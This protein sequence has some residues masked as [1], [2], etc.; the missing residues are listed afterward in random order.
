[1]SERKKKP[2]SR[3][4]AP[5]CLNSRLLIFCW[6][7]VWLGR[8]RALELE[9]LPELSASFHAQPIAERINVLWEAEL[10]RK[11]PSLPR[12][13]LRF[14]SFD[15]TMGF[16]T[17]I[18][19]GMLTAAARPFLLRH[20]VQNVG[21]LALSDVLLLSV[22]LVLEAFFQSWNKQFL[23]DRL[24]CR[25]GAACISLISKRIPMGAGA[26]QSSKGGAQPTEA[27]LVGTDVVRTL[28]NSMILIQFFT[29]I[30]Q[31]CCSVVVLL[32]IVGYPSLLGIAICVMCVFGAGRA[33]KY[34]KQIDKRVLQQTDR[35]IGLLKQILDG[36][37]FIKVSG[38]E[39]FYMDKSTSIRSLETVQQRRYRIF[40]SFGITFGR[41]T[42]P[43]ASMATFVFM[44]FLEEPLKASDVFAAMS[45]FM[46][47]RMPLAVIPACMN[48]VMTAL[49]SCNRIGRVISAPVVAVPPDTDNPMNVLALRDVDL[50]W[51]AEAPL[52]LQGVS[53]DIRVG[54]SVGV[55]GSVAS[56]KSTLLMS[57]IGGLVPSKGVAARSATC[58]KISYVPQRPIVFSGSLLSNVIMGD[59]LDE[60]HLAAAL[61]AAQF[62]RD[63]ELMPGGL[64]TEIGERGTTLSGGQQMRL[65]IARALYHSPQLLVAD[66]PIAA[67]DVH[68]GGLIFAAL[69][70]W[71]KGPSRV[72][73]D[74][75]ESRTL[76]MSLNQLHMLPDFHKVVYLHGGRVAFQGTPSELDVAKAD[77]ESLSSLLQSAAMAVTVDDI[78]V[79]AGSPVEKRAST[80]LPFE[81]GKKPAGFLET[82]KEQP[83]TSLMS[84]SS[85]GKL[86]KEEHRVRGSMSNNVLL[87]YVIAVGAKLSTAYGLSCLVTYALL[88][89]NDWYLAWWM[90]ELEKTS[91]DSFKY[92]GAAI[93]VGLTLSHGAGMIISN[94]FCASSGARAARNLHKTSLSSVL[95]AP[96]S[97]FEETP[98]GRI[99]SKFSADL[100][101]V[102]LKLPL[103]IDHFIVVGS[104]LMVFSISIC[105][106]VPWFALFLVVLIPV[107]FKL[108]SLVNKSSREIKRMTNMA[109]SPVLTFVQEASA[110]RLLLRLMKQE[111]WLHNETVHYIDD[112]H[113]LYFN[114][115]SMLCFLRLVGS[116]LGTS[117]SVSVI[118]FFWAI[119]SL[120][121]SPPGGTSNAGLA[122]AYAFIIPY[123][124]SYLTLFAS[125]ARLFL[126][127]L[128]RLLE[129]QS[130]RM[131][132]EKPWSCKG[133]PGENWPHEG[134]IEFKE[135]T[136]RYK[137][138]LPAAVNSL[139]LTINGGERLGVVGRTG[140]G[141]SSL[142]ILLLRIVEPDGGTVLIDGVD[143]CEIGLHAL[144]RAVAVV[145]QEP[146]LFQGPLRQNLDPLD[147]YTE[148]ALLEALSRVSLEMKL[149]TEVGQGGGQLSAGERQLIAIARA[150]MSTARIIIM[151]EPTAN[152]DTQTDDRLQQVTRNAFKSRTVLCIAHRLNT[153]MEYD[154][155][156]VMEAGSV[157]EVD[158]PANL[159]AMPT[160][161]FAQMVSKMNRGS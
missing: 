36:V 95:H 3:P 119:P 104:T 78:A 70:S 35:R 108:D 17:S 129:L 125:Q 65:N 75:W 18:V 23:C 93:Y 107:F 57:M 128:E 148:E 1:M 157:A 83:R 156:L 43:V 136:M 32:I 138:D 124:L 74:D 97:W 21:D 117:V 7:L 64:A 85:G 19:H 160:G 150:T 29:G 158:T 109:L 71:Q 54:Q 68:V 37:R 34:S 77:Q 96:V 30:T 120:G 153:V 73:I 52:A 88:A 154:R 87:Q 135:S 59:P 91:D 58:L 72:D 161:H 46:S 103:F 98:S 99:L 38:W 155:V 44:A 56:G 4:P 31:L 42:P 110:A 105:V 15:L 39:S 16:C 116:L 126:A 106:I 50:Q 49:N 5:G 6:R 113:S 12:L 133:D 20:V 152:C 48:I 25:T 62:T 130:I 122:V 51:S 28:E 94:I 60:K 102:D 143:I 131:P 8:R 139:T 101:G 132:Q 149:D 140:A 121:H 27:T 146:F 134:A 45:L 147:M 14:N 111:H 80:A 11:N 127:G 118:F 112:Y 47:L 142:S 63:L 82:K 159:L 100:T 84:A 90:G 69:Q 41:I 9:D 115:Q 76:V 144:R 141:K 114:S 81:V 145:P 67:V 40:E 33:S 53:I 24:A 26:A 66:D 61:E 137:P 89:A 151:D 2:S 79:D 55:I 86:F 10:Q 92:R 22:V 13:L 123:F